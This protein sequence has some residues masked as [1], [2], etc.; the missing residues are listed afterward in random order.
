ML[1]L[2]G[3]CLSHACEVSFG[4]KRDDN[5]KENRGNSPARGRLAKP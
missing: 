3:L 2:L 4:K 1:R 5:R